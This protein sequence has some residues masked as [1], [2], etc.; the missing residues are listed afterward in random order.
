MISRIKK[1]TDFPKIVAAKVTFT[2]EVIEVLLV[3][4]IVSYI[5]YLYILYFFFYPFGVF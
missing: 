3:S 4:Q 5:I 2:L 1:K